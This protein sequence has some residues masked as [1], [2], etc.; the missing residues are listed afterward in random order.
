MAKVKGE[1]LDSGHDVDNFKAR[2]IIAVEFQ[3][4][5]KNFK[6]SKK[7]NNV[8]IYLFRLLGVYLIDAPALSM[9]SSPEKQ[10]REDNEGIVMSPKTKKTIISINPLKY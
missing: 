3:L 2:A 7:T 6:V 8:K 9:M 5:S 1:Y 10:R 4:V